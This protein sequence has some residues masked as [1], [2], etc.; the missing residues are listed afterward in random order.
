[1]CVCVCACACVRACARPYMCIHLDTTTTTTTILFNNCRVKQLYIAVQA[2]LLVL[3]IP[4]TLE[5]L[6]EEHLS[7]VKELLCL[8]IQAA[9]AAYAV[10]VASLTKAA[11]PDNGKFYT[12]FC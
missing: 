6:N 5:P 2:S 7:Q 11:Q 3:T 9:V 12:L 1:M 8:L 10:P 4:D